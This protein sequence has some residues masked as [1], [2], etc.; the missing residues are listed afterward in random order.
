MS[1]QRI[2]HFYS[3]QTDLI[4]DV[5]SPSEYQHAHI[6]GA[7]NLPLFTDEERSVVGTLYKQ[8]G[9]HEAIKTGLTYFGPRMKEM[10]LTVEEWLRQ[11]YELNADVELIPSDYTLL[12]HCWRGG[13][14]SGE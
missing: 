1:I 12:V 5:R 11:K 14:R 2:S 9:R 3:W 13:M 8:T 10:V 4:L 7:L 6:P